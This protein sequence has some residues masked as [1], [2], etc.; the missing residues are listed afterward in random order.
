MQ[1]HLKVKKIA[2]LGAGVM[3]AQIA[4]HCINSG[5]ETLLF[6]LHP[7]K[8][9]N[10]NDLVQQAINHLIKLKPAPLALPQM[11][12]LIQAKNYDD[13][14]ADLTNCD[15][16]IEAI[17]ERLDFKI[18]LYKLI[19]PHL[20]NKAILVTNTSGLS[21]NTLCQIL[22]VHLQ[23]NF[24]GMHF[25]NP[26]RYMHLVELIP[27]TKTSLILLGKLESWLTSYLGKGVVR[28]KDTPNFIANRIGVFSLLATWK[29]AELMQ[30]GFDEVDLLTGTLIGRPKSATF[31]TIDLV[32]LDT[33]RHVVSTMQESLQKDQWHPLF[34]LP[35]WFNKMINDN[36]LG[37][38]T[39]QGI[40]RK[41]GKAIEVFDINI[42]DYRLA[43]ANIDET[44]K[45]IF[46]I[47]EPQKFFQNLI[48]STSKQAKFLTACY[49]DLWHYSVYHL[50]EI[51]N[52]VRDVDLAMCWGF[53]WQQ[54]PFEMWQKIGFSTVKDFIQQALNDNLTLSKVNIPKWLNTITDF[55][56]PQ[57]AYNP[58][59]ETYNP[60]SK[61][62]VYSRQL[63]KKLSFSKG[64]QN[65]LFDND[66]IYAYHLDDDLAVVS[67]K[68]KA[69]TIGQAI[70]DGF[71]E[72]LKIAADKCQG[73]IIYQD[74]PTNFGAGAD[75][76]AVSQTMETKKLYILEN[77][78]T[79]FQQ[80]VMQIKYSPIPII[81]ALRGRALGGSCELILHCA[82]IVAAFESYPGLVE[83]GVGLLPA[84]GGCKEM[85]LRA[86]KAAKNAD[87]LLFLQPYFEQIATGF[88]A[89]NALEAQKKGYLGEKDSWVMHQDEV[90]FASC[91]KIKAL[92]AANYQPPLKTK[93]KV[94]GIE[95]HARLQAGL[96]NWLEGGFISKHD[97]FLANKI[98]YVL[99]GGELNQG[100][101]V[102]ENWFLHL[103][104]EAFMMMANEP[105]TQERIKFL[106]T[107][108]KHLRN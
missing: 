81:A 99:C 3:G 77:M 38:K 102:D 16:I 75:L 64:A 100:M 29:H 73:L 31:R 17:A 10:N 65:K 91:A 30:I 92:Q 97:Y 103:E 83:A 14:L 46:K 36:H 22:P 59:T 61:L 5:I 42:N 21:I 26:P 79:N 74:D 57:G 72:I 82:E 68:S 66:Q 84:G 41:K 94:A 7:S 23:N 80:L 53:G 13:D 43:N 8:N 67:F 18:D 86:Q 1:E 2:V 104:K 49:I 101:E 50:A 55:Y 88:V 106:L 39:G 44:V 37:Q 47:K 54:G 4:A 27:A 96:V 9:K 19:T 105:L 56:N 34:Q 60:S 20:N 70:I 11:A 98:A 45:E 24:C 62:P 48:T 87:L 33:M 108:G 76:Q 32:G 51:A 6:D 52:N 69:N 63:A 85:A 95:G 89:N 71:L 78:I 90:L 25:F 28:C 93:I 35:K 15:L 107:S 58:E 12:A 40:Y